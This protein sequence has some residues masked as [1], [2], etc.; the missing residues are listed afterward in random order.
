MN[1]LDYIEYTFEKRAASKAALRKAKA[2]VAEGV[3]RHQ[4]L[5]TMGRYHKA[6]DLLRQHQYGRRAAKRLAVGGGRSY[7]SSKSPNV[8]SA[9]P[10]FPMRAAQDA[11]LGQVIK[12][13]PGAGVKRVGKNSPLFKEVEAKGERLK[14]GAFNPTLKGVTKQQKMMGVPRKS[15][16]TRMIK[17]F[18]RPISFDK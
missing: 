10:Y 13:M 15:A 9:D 3:S 8:K 14:R 16:V 5:G 7:G 6:Q 1:I 12:R 2:I 4:R 18:N 11:A 17:R